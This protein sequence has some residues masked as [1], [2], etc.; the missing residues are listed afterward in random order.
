M[1]DC[2]KLDVCDILRHFAREVP[3]RVMHC[4]PLLYAVLAFASRNMSIMAGVD[5]IDSSDYHSK[6]LQ[7]L[8]PALDKIGDTIDENLLTTIVILRLYE[9]RASE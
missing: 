8:I 7:R 3:L 4:P 1:I 5:D 6:C 9:E 2:I